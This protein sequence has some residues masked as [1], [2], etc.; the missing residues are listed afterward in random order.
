MIYIN[1]DHRKRLPIVRI[2]KIHLENFKNVKKGEILCEC[3]RTF[4][5]QG[6]ESDIIGLYGQNG[7]GKTTIIQALQL[8]QYLLVGYPMT[9]EFSDFISAD[10]DTAFLSYT[11]DLQYEDGRQREVVYTFKIAQSKNQ[12]SSRLFSNNGRFFDIMESLVNRG[13]VLRIYDE[14]IQMSGVF[15]DKSIKRQTVIDT[16][17]SDSVF[18]FGPASKRKYFITEENKNIL[19]ANKLSS[20]K[21]CTSFIFESDTLKEFA[22]INSEYFE[23]I[24]ELVYFA[25]RNLYIITTNNYGAISSSKLLPLH[26]KRPTLTAINASLLMEG[27]MSEEI[28]SEIYKDESYNSLM[29]DEDFQRGIVDVLPSINPIYFPLS[30]TIEIL[31]SEY[32][33]IESEINSISLVLSSLIPGNEIFLRKNSESTNARG[34]EIIFADLMIRKNG[35]ELPL[36]YES[37]GTI[38]LIGMLNCLIM[39]YNKKSVTVAIDEI[40]SGVFEYLLGEIL[41]IFE[42]GG[43]GQLFFTSHNLRPLEVLNKKYLFFTTTDENNRYVHLK[44]IGK[45]N[46]L[47]NVY[48]R[49]ILEME[50]DDVSFYSGT[51]KYKIATAFRKAGVNE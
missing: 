1:E 3:G 34:Q 50:G 17:L 8:L 15:Y 29:N 9:A 33:Y 48:Y 43:R 20:E 32:S 44:N 19:Y 46:N 26:T 35:K 13:T 14:C 10:A 40:D 23:V 31:K 24:A 4:I 36:R 6:T 21:N 27:I 28:E 39:A 16:S 5:E 22:K 38:K 2:K 51:Q 18:V 45:T 30:S 42:E 47:R 41:Q 12:N 37:D 11:F 7:S 25:Q 49:E